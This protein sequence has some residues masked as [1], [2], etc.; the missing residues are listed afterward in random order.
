MGS[1]DKEWSAQHGPS[2]QLDVKAAIR[3]LSDIE[4]QGFRRNE[5][6]ASIE[7][8]SNEHYSDSVTW[9]VKL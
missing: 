3:M 8:A 4:L 2:S 5:L 7:M 6:S 9:D 1:R